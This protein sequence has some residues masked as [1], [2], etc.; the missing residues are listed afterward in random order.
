MKIPPQAELHIKGR[1]QGTNEQKKKKAR[2][3]VI[4]SHN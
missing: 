2:Y 3:K 4:L 1:L